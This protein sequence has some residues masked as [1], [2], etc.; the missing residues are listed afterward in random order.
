MP[1]PT[2]RPRSLSFMAC[3]PEDFAFFLTELQRIDSGAEWHVIAFYPPPCEVPPQMTVTVS[4]RSARVA[5]MLWVGS[6]LHRFRR[7]IV[8]CRDVSE[9]AA[10][11]S[12]IQF[13]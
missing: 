5:I 10:L 6:F 9:P 4:S 8:C 7:V 11:Q 13:V 1:D 12:L 2:N 3:P